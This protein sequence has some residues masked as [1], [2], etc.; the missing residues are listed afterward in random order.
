MKDEEESKRNDESVHLTFEKG[1]ESVA[2]KIGL[3]LAL[4]SLNWESLIEK[5]FAKKQLCVKLWKL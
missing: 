3:A 2:N 5:T 1:S 4:Q